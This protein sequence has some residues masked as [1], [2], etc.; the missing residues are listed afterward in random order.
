MEPCDKI[1]DF[2]RIPKALGNI[3][4]NLRA[5]MLLGLVDTWFPIDYSTQNSSIKEEEENLDD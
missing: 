3:S 1:A 4:Q 2:E 5:F